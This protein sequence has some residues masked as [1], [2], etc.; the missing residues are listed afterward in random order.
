MPPLPESPPANTAVPRLRVL[1]ITDEME[2]GGSQRQIVNLAC[3]LD[4]LR[5]EVTVAYFRN[6]SFLVDEL[7]RAGVRVVHLPKRGRVDLRF[8]G[9]LIYELRAGRYDIVHAF[10][11]SAELWA[12][13]ARRAL[14]TSRRGALFTSVRG[15]YDWYG[16]LHWRLK[17]WVTHQSTRVVA[18]SNIGAAYASERMHVPRRAIDVVYNGVRAEA[19]GLS[20]RSALRREW[21]LGSGVTVALFVGRL[22]ELKDVATLVRAAA[23]TAA[24]GTTLRYVVCGDG[25]ERAALEAQVL[26][27]GLQ[28]HVRFLGERADV[29]RLIDAAD[30]VVLTSR[31]E[32]LSNVILEA[33]RGARPVVASQAG[34]NV[35]LVVP[36][37][38][39]LLFPVGDDAALAVALQR[40]A[41]DSHLREVLGHQGALRVEQTFAIDAM[42]GSFAR[43]YREAYGQPG[44]MKPAMTAQV[45]GD[46]RNLG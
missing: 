8:L 41:A 42:A 6:R 18:N 31:Q 21:G 19:A 11:F 16:R 34:G 4:P 3:G 43:L 13:I 10:A 27:L 38:T 37:S 26:S 20:Q 29:A 39:G 45:R 36:E 40:L 5:H 25:P 12:A 2:V 32:G 7:L 44:R 14:P 30:L 23:R 17:R 35:E 1:I 24:A 22:V 28:E 33:M 9:S 46:V 15:T